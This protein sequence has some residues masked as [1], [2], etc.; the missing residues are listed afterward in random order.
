M[1]NKTFWY[2][3]IDV[4]PLENNHDLDGASGAFVNVIYKADSEADFVTT[5]KESFDEYNFAVV[6]IEDIEC[7]PHFEINDEEGSEKQNLIDKIKTEGLDFCW[8]TFHTYK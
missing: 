7:Y 4:E 1:E 2:G 3:L 6:E 5:V 8:G